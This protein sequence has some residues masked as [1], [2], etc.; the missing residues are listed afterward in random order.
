MG[1]DGECFVARSAE[2]RQI[3]WKDRANTAAIA[4]HTNAFKINEDV[5]IPLD[6]KMLH[7]N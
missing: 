2:K 6:K 1:R 4:A 5:V 3:F 7:A